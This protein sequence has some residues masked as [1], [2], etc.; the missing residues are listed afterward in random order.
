MIVWCTNM[1]AHMHACTHACT[2]TLTSIFSFP[3]VRSIY[4]IFLSA[5]LFR[6]LTDVSHK[7]WWNTKYLLSALV[8][9]TILNPKLSPV[10]RYKVRHST[11]HVKSCQPQSLVSHKYLRNW[12]TSYFGMVSHNNLIFFALCRYCSKLNIPP[13]RNCQPQI[14][15]K[16]KTEFQRIPQM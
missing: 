4:L 13:K 10:S 11:C 9:C 8:L 16:I 6:H 14:L 15:V 5:T 7:F 2:H 12:K 3:Q 1:H